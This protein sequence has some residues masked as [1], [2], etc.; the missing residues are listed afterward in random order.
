MARGPSQQSDQADGAPQARRVTSI[1]ADEVN[2]SRTESEQSA[3]DAEQSSADSDQSIADRDQVSSDKDQ[4]AADRDQAASDRDLAAGG[5]DVTH[6]ATQLV[7]RQTAVQRDADSQIRVDAAARRDEIAER[8]DAAASMRDRA[9]DAHDALMDRADAEERRR[10][11]ERDD[12]TSEIVRTAAERRQVAAVLRREA[13]AARAMAASDRQAAAADRE[14]AAADRSRARGMSERLLTR[15]SSAETDE[16]TGA[17]VR[18]AGLQ[19]L[20]GEL[21][22]CRRTNCPLVVAYVD[23]VGLKA[24]ND[25]DGHAAGDDLLKHVV[26]VISRG[27]RSY[28]HVVR[29]G[30]DEFLCAMSDATLRDARERFRAIVARLASSSASPGIR[31][32]FA[33]ARPDEDVAQLISRADAEMLRSTGRDAPGVRRST[34]VRR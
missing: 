13:A 15:L 27:L 20:R 29:L 4:D 28:D 2:A 11:L 8:R 9:A 19:D 14:Q 10:D 3:A 1:I 12:A 17:R 26:D 16:L 31:V 23:I 5:D 32:G 25:A 18:A 21:D 30:G 22:R 33:E 7:R 24:V 34:P 6:D